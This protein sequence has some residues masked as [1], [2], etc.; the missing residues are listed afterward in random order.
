L[1]YSCWRGPGLIIS[2]DSGVEYTNQTGGYGCLSPLLEGVFVPLFDCEVDQEEMLAEYFSEIKYHCTCMNGI[3]AKDADFID[4]IFSLGYYTHFLKVDRE[5]LQLSHEAWIY[6]T[7]NNTSV[8]SDLS[9]TT[10]VLYGFYRSKGVVT[11]E[12][13]D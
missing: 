12:N 1:R 7:I 13:S 9:E 3:D 6:V 8:V 10:E 11:W 2:T 4:K 5:K